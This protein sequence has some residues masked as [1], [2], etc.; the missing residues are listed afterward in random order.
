MESLKKLSESET[1]PTQEELREKY[2]TGVV[3]LNKKHSTAIQ[4]KQDMMNKEIDFD[5]YTCYEGHT[6][7][8]TAAQM[9]ACE[10]FITEIETVKTRI[11]I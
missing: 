4:Q 3:E 2:T 6:P 1:P 7:N 8:M 11:Q 9:S 10:F 5:V